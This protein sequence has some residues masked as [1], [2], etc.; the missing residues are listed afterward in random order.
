MWN[1]V[2]KFARNQIKIKSSKDKAFW[3]ETKSFL[4][5]KASSVELKRGKT[6]V[7]QFFHSPW[8]RPPPLPNYV[9]RGK[10]VTAAY[11]HKALQ[12][13]GVVFGPKRPSM[14][15]QN[16]FFAR[17]PNKLPLALLF[18][19]IGSGKRHQ[20]VLRAPLLLYFTPAAFYIFLKVKSE[21][22]SCLMTQGVAP[23]I[24]TKELGPAVLW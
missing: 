22:A 18:S 3:D 8:R 16:L 15:V 2:A 11:I 21:L 24:A 17:P 6:P 1:F 13:F 14:S 19:I 12:R 7:N 10:T 5:Y 9:P 23:T 20:D 4:Q